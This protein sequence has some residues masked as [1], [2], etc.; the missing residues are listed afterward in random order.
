MLFSSPPGPVLLW[1]YPFDTRRVFFIIP[2][3]RVY[4]QDEFKAPVKT[5]HYSE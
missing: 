3:L 5:E 4:N 1:C 2:V